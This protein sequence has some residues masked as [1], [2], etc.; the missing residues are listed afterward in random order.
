MHL[1]CRPLNGPIGV[2]IRNE[3]I[4]MTFIDGPRHHPDLH[5]GVCRAWSRARRFEIDRGEAALVKKFHLR[6]K[7][8]EEE[9][10]G[11]SGGYIGFSPWREC[12][13]RGIFFNVRLTKDSAPRGR[14]ALPF[15]KDWD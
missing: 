15:F 13:A 14:V 12:L 1:A 7:N 3:G 8:Q 2:E 9:A 4:V 11:R 10:R 6:N 5:R